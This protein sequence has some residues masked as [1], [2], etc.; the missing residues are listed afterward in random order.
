LVQAHKCGGLKPVNGIPN[1][2]SSYL[3][4][5]RQY[6][7][8]QTKIKTCT[9]SLPLCEVSC[10]VICQPLFVFLSL[11]LLTGEDGNKGANGNKG[12]KGDK[13]DTGDKGP[14]G[15]KGNHYFIITAN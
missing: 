14:H 13:G 3:D 6:I 10:V 7:Y 15:N 2:C 1:M 11:F 12:E 8:K 4:L 9:V 5:Q